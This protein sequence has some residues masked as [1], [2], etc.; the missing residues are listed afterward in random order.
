MTTRK[1]YKATLD[2]ALLVVTSN[3]NILWPKII[4]N[5][6]FVTKLHPKVMGTIILIKSRP[7][8]FSR[9]R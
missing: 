8:L 7:V 1:F 4:G 9:Q 6:D 3:R 2:G 5:S